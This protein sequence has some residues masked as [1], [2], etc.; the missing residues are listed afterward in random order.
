MLFSVEFQVY[1]EPATS[2]FLPIFSFV[3]KNV[4]PHNYIVGTHNLF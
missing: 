4:L 2:V 3:N 1:L